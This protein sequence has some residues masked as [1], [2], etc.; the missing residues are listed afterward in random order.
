MYYVDIMRTHIGH[1]GL[2][3]C[4]RNSWG[5]CELKKATVTEH[6]GHMVSDFGHGFI[7]STYQ[8]FFRIMGGTAN[9]S[10]KALSKI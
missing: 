3:Q 1:S 7:S 4:I 9:R 8:F 10:T 5:F 6:E 2:L